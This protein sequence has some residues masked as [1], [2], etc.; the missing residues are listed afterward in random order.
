VNFYTGAY[1]NV[2]G[3]TWVNMTLR[4]TNLFDN[5]EIAASIK[6]VFDVKAFEPSD[7]R[8]PDNYPLDER[9]Y[10]IEVRYRQ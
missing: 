5:W 4:K 6:N 3:Y 9:A 7:G 8:I 10:Y 1:E 2:A